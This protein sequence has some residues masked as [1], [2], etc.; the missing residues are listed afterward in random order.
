MRYQTMRKRGPSAWV[1]NLQ[2][3]LVSL[4]VVFGLSGCGGSSS[5]SNPPSSNPVPSISSL[6]PSSATTGGAA[7]NLT[8]RGTNFISSSTLQWN[9]TGLTTTFVSATQ[10]TAAVTAAD[11]AAAGTA[12]VS[13]VNPAP[14][15]GTSSAASFTINNPAPSISSLS[16]ASALLGG[17]SFTLTV[18]GSNFVSNSTVQWNG[19][20]LTT[21]VVSATQL[22]ATVLA[23]DIAADGTASVAVVNP[24]PGGGH[25]QRS[26]SPS[27]TR[28]L[29]SHRCLLL[30]SSPVGR[31]LPS[32]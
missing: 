15:G 20:S 18:N 8:V 28:C 9:G 26:V 7:F 14:G 2:L 23:S 21:T 27:I 10:L 32:R 6:S 19:A 4:V 17:S 3:S 24:A 30:P 16:P 12:N 5:S 13:A 11:I 1:V 22:K 31:R 29:Q 25:P